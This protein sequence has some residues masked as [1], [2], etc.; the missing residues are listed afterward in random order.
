MEWLKELLKDVPDSEKLMESIQKELPKYFKPAEV[1]NTVNNELKAT[2][3]QL[4]G[5]NTT[6][7]QL[8]QKSQTADEYKTQLDKLNLEHAEFVKNADKRV[9]EVKKSHILQNSLLEA[10][11][12]KSAVDLLAGTIDLNTIE[13]ADGKIKGFDD[14]LKPIKESRPTLFKVESVGGEP[15]AKPPAG[16][17]TVD[18]SSLREIMGLPPTV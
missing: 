6:L 8:T 12:D 18:N 1:F 11:A 15:P 13:L 2:K 3:E 16:S 4:A 10:G 9:E 14:L 5:M 17:P 7:E